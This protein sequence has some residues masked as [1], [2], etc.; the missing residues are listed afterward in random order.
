M[1]YGDDLN[2]F[3][4]W[5]SHFI[6]SI[7]S[8]SLQLLFISPWNFIGFPYLFNLEYGAL[9]PLIL[10][11]L[12]FGASGYINFVYLF[13]ISIS[14]YGTWVFIRKGLRLG[15]YSAI[16][17]AFV[18]T[19]N[20]FVFPR[21][22]A[23]HL[24]VI[25]TY[26][27]IPLCLYGISKFSETNK[28]KYLVLFLSCVYLQLTSGFIN[29]FIIS[30]FIYALWFVVCLKRPRLKSIFN[31]LIDFKKIFAI[32]VFLATILLI[33]ILFSQ[34]ISQS[35]R[36]GIKEYKFSSS[37]SLPILNLTTFL[38]PDHL[39]SPIY[40]DTLLH[41]NSYRGDFNFWELSAFFGVSA[42]MLC[43]VGLFWKFRIAF[44]WLVM[45]VL[46][47]VLS[48]GSN[49]PVFEYIFRYIPFYRFIRIPAQHL[50]LVTLSA[51]I[52]S[53]YGLEYFKQ[54]Q[55]KKGQRLSNII[56]I[57]II[58]MSS[59]SALAIMTKTT[60]YY[61]MLHTSTYYYDD[62][63]DKEVLINGKTNGLSTIDVKKL[64]NVELLDQGNW[65]IINTTLTT[66]S[67]D[68]DS[69][70][71][72]LKTGIFGITQ[73]QIETI[74]VNKKNALEIY[75]SHDNNSWSRV[76][77]SK[78]GLFGPTP[79]NTQRSTIRN[80]PNKT[81]F[82]KISKVSG[83]SPTGIDRLSIFSI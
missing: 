26:S 69:L 20:G 73:I 81:I 13:S 41:T 11:S 48:L 52:L 6:F 59:I 74:N 10:T 61:L 28:T 70:V 17:G 32:S 24:N 36:A 23:G 54:E 37:Y 9:N 4:F 5:A 62:F 47:I 63:G 38:N 35:Q 75:Y 55:N 15:S 16:L 39:G 12:I 83:E 31:H 40:K 66:G 82:I 64:K 19:F 68:S 67:T 72:K 21:I 44:F 57:V 25:S 34:I 43:L 58:I 30:S 29:I 76:G 77:Q 8:W 46:G 27:W 49:T 1:I 14:F 42:L 53:A 79:L 33:T 78:F 60:G 18:F 50:F 65:K 45:M 7:K 2:Q 3:F 80:W 22:Y 56:G 71:F 51:A